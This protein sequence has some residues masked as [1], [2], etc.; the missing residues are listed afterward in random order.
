MT[1]VGNITEHTVTTVSPPSP[2]TRLAGQEEGEEGDTNILTSLHHMEA[3][4]GEAREVDSLN[5]LG[6]K[7][8]DFLAE[9]TVALGKTVML[10]VSALLVGILPGRGLGNLWPLYQSRVFGPEISTHF[11][12]PYSFLHFEVSRV[13]WWLGNRVGADNCSMLRVSTA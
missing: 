6:D 2:L 10:C 7:L 9:S 4:E 13:W 11:L 1:A 8:S 12:D 3:G 5:I